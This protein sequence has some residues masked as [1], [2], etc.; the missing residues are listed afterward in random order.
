LLQ[1]FELDLLNGHKIKPY[2]GATLE[3]RPGV[4][5]RIHRRK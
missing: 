5:I 3:P 2:M 4:I 1:T